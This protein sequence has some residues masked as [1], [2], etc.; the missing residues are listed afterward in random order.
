MTFLHT[1]LSRRRV[2]KGLG[3]G[4]LAGLLYG[5]GAALAERG[6]AATAPG[7]PPPSGD[8]AASLVFVLAHPGAPAVL[9]PPPAPLAGHYVSFSLLT[10]GA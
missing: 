8:W 6:P 5:R 1:P 4:G 10:A 3:L 2:I 9:P 7:S